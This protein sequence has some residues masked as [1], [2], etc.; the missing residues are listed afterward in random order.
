[1]SGDAA[2][3]SACGAGCSDGDEAEAGDSPD[4]R[5]AD[6]DTASAEPCD[7]DSGDSSGMPARTLVEKG[8][9]ALTSLL[10]LLGAMRGDEAKGERGGCSGDTCAAR[11]CRAGLAAAAGDAE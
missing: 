2:A 5:T 11:G 1:M 8:R 3:A 6:G 10:G 4:S 7:G 9:T